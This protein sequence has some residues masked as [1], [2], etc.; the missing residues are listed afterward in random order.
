MPGRPKHADASS[1]DA[2]TRDRLLAE[3]ERL[4]MAQGFAAIS[5][6]Q[7]CDAAH[8]TQ[9]SLYHFFT[10]KEGLYLAVV[11]RWFAQVH[12]GI[13]Q[14]ISDGATL[15]GQLH[16]VALLFWA[17]VA[18][19]YQAM[20]RDAM[21]YLSPQHRHTLGLTV[22]RSVVEPLLHL[23]RDG[24][25]QGAL[26]ANIDPFILTE[27]FWAVVDGIS[28]I[29]MRGD[30]IPPPDQNMAAIDFFLAGVRGIDPA[31][32]A[33]WPQPGDQFALFFADDR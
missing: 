18:G 22:L 17:G 16:R 31:T 2:A 3:A 6:R 30:P 23:M 15:R 24:A 21:T 4:F 26:P 8:V 13:V 19:E 7:I 20:Q 32:F 28:G 25:T 5:T 29:Y 14:A 33:D 1:G 27:M 9:P 10:N 11:E 12:Q